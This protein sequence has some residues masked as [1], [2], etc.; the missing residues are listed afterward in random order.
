MC[1]AQPSAIVRALFGPT[2]ASVCAGAVLAASVACDPF[3][4]VC[5]TVRTCSD[6]RPLAGARVN[7]RY[8]GTSDSL[9][10]EGTTDA[11]GRY[12]TSAM[13][14]SPPATYILDVSDPGFPDA[15][16]PIDHERSNSDVC[17]SATCDGCL[18]RDG[19]V[20]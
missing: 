15:S 18:A 1:I 13:G 11:F 14:D 16:I 12:C 9:G 20:D 6:G 8:V 10:D 17:V 2:L 5:V 7:F 3:Y 4:K 19:A